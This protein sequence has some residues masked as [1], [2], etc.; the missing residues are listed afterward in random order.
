MAIYV[1][2]GSDEGRV[3]EEA[4]ALF[5]E[6]KPPGSDEFANEI[7]I[8]AFTQTPLKLDVLEKIIRDVLNGTP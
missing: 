4:A 2:T 8:K 7:G 5:E 3:A 1:V 6:L